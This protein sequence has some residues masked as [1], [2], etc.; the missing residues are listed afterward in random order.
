MLNMNNLNMYFNGVAFGGETKLAQLHAN[1]EG[2]DTVHISVDLNNLDAARENIDTLTEDFKTFLTH[3]LTVS[4]HDI[5]LTTTESNE[6]E[7]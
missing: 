2:K 5:I 6:G 3:V 7:V 1:Y 4:D